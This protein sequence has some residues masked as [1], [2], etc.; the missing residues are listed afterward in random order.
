MPTGDSQREGCVLQLHHRVVLPP[1]ASLAERLRARFGDRQRSFDE[2][3]SRVRADA[4]LVPL[5]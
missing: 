3:G 2:L 1:A 5:R 4:D